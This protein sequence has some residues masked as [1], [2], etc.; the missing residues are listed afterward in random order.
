MTDGSGAR[1]PYLVMEL[2]DGQPLSALM[3]PGV[4]HGPG[5]R[6]ASCSPRRPTGS[7]P[8]TPPASC[9]AT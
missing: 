8:R 7:A 3:R 5:R 4:P 6:S 9:T 2:V 1:R